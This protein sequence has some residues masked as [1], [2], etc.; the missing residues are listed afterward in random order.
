MTR[1]IVF[2][3][4]ICVAFSSGQVKKDP[5][6]LGLAGTYSTISR[7]I[8]A[9]G[10]N[11]ANLAFYEDKTMNIS[12]G[13]VYFKAT[14]SSLSLTDLN[15]YNGLDLEEIDPYTNEPYKNDFM[16]LFPDEGLNLYTHLDVSIPFMSISRKNI[17]YTN[18]LEWIR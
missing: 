17:A 16:E 5:R 10:W 13:N 14:N 3:L 15:K 4:V 7:G 18:D 9:V 6:A 11:P 8:F 12:L 1:R 2:F